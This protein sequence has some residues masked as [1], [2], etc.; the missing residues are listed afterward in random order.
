MCVC[1]CE[2]M[3]VCVHASARVRGCVVCVGASEYV[4]VRGC[5]CGCTCVGAWFVWVRPSMCACVN[6]RVVHVCVVRA[7][8]S[9]PVGAVE[10]ERASGG[11]LPS[12]HIARER[13]FRA[14]AS[15]CREGAQQGAALTLG[16]LPSPQ[17]FSSS[18]CVGGLRSILPPPPVALVNNVAAF[19]Q[20]RI[21]R[22]LYPCNL[23]AYLVAAFC[24]SQRVE[25][26]PILRLNC[27]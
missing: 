6:A 23:G 9:A 17:S 22:Y 13:A 16:R 2:R 18:S 14:G 7:W 25:T 11:T 10:R 20:K 5:A 26:C 12:R 4:C 27:A 19:G 21:R 24:G 8:H 1:A 15:G 3:C